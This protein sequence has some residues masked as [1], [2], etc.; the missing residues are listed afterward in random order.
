MVTKKEKTPQDVGKAFEDEINQKRKKGEPRIEVVFVPVHRD[1]L[2]KDIVEGKGDIAIANLTI[3]PERQKFADFSVP[4]LTDVKEIVVT[5]P[6]SPE[7]KTLDDLSGKKIFVRPTSSYFQSLWH[8]N[9]E[10]S[11]KGKP[12]VVVE[13][14]PEELEDDARE[15]AENCP[16][17]AITLE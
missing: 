14:A 8:L 10:F 11:K 12:G 6:Q 5:G 7:I 13:Q 4:V 9:E 15:A 3:T 2:L 1:D 16:V 17:S